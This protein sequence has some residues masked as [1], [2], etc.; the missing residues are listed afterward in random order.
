MN[1]I[2]EEREDIIKNNN[3]A[4]DILLGILENLDI[5]SRELVIVEA[6]YGN[7]NFSV[8]SDKGFRN[9]KN[10][11]IKEEGKITDISNLP[12]GLEKLI[13]SNQYLIELENLPKTLKELDCQGNFISDMDVYGL[14]KLF[15]LQVSNNQLTKLENLPDSLEELYCNNNKIN[16]LNLKDLLSLRILHTSNNRAII[17]ENLPPSIVDFQSENNPYIEID[18]ANMHGKKSSKK[19]DNENEETIQYMESIFDYFKLKKKYEEKLYTDRKKAFSKGTTVK[20]GKKLASKVIPKCI[21]CKQPGGTIFRSKD[22]TYYATCG[23]QS[24]PCNLKIEI[25]NGYF[26][27]DHIFKIE[28]EELENIQTKM[29]QQKLDNIFNYANEKESLQKFKKNLEEFN[30]FNNDI[31]ELL[32]KNNH[33]YKDPLREELIHR[34]NRKIYELINA[35]KKII[36]QYEK[37]GNPHLLKTA[38]EIQVK[39]LNPEIHNLRLLKHEDMEM[40]TKIIVPREGSDETTH[41]EY[42]LIQRYCSIQ[43]IHHSKGRPPSVVRYNVK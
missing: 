21:N 39:E 9:I 15:F 20:S 38:V 5:G 14:K 8:L 28:L 23:N 3:T 17:I 35:I 37:D 10:I 27:N 33:L 43:K 31:V 25:Y 26:E 16:V 7:L 19:Q 41:M 36:I 6:L 2:R 29:I 34:K 32:E 13:C 18:Y 30:Y 40:E 22:E 12:D 42:T 24:N 11:V 4:Q 1:I